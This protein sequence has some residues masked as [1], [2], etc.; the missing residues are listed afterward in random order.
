LDAIS[1]FLQLELGQESSYLT[2]FATSFG[3]Y[4]FLRLLYGISCSPE[5]L[6]RTVKEIFEDID[7]V[8]CYVDDLLIHAP[9]ETEHDVILR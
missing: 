5:I 9:T 7:G 2:T 3:R 1:G 8:E 4:R 6:C